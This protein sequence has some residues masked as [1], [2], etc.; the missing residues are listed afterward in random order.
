MGVAA[1]AKPSP[2]EGEGYEA[3]AT[4]SPR[5]SWMRGKTRSQA[6]ALHLHHPHPASTR[7]ALLT[8]SAQPSPFKGEGLEALR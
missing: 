4:Q 3:L 6:L 5:C 1:R 8:K 7:F 2:L